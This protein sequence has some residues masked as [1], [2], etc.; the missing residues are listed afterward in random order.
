MIDKKSTADYIGL[1][2]IILTSFIPVS[3]NCP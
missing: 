3:K 2:L 1:T